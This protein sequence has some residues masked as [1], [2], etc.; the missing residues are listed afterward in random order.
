MLDYTCAPWATACAHDSRFASHTAGVSNCVRISAVEMTASREGDSRQIDLVIVTSSEHI[1]EEEQY[2]SVQEDRGTSRRGEDHLKNSSNNTIKQ[3]SEEQCS[4]QRLAACG[5]AGVIRIDYLKL[6]VDLCG[7]RATHAMGSGATQLRR[8]SVCGVIAA[9]RVEESMSQTVRVGHGFDSGDEYPH[10]GRWGEAGRSLS[11]KSAGHAARLGYR[12]EVVSLAAHSRLPFVVCSL[13]SGE[14]LVWMGPDMLCGAA[15]MRCTGFAWGQYGQVAWGG[16]SEGGRMVWESSLLWALGQDGKSLAAFPIWKSESTAPSQMSPCYSLQVGDDMNNDLQVDVG[17]KRLF[18][19]MDQWSS[20]DAA[21]PHIVVVLACGLLHALRVS[22]VADGL[23]H[24]FVT[25]HVLVGRVPL[26]GMPV[27]CVSAADFLESDWRAKSSSGTAPTGEEALLQGS[28]SSGSESAGDERAGGWPTLLGVDRNAVIRYEVQRDLITVSREAILPCDLAEKIRLDRCLKTVSLNSMQVIAVVMDPNTVGAG[29]AVGYV[30]ECRNNGLQDVC[31]PMSR[32]TI[33][34]F[35]SND[36]LKATV[37]RSSRIWKLHSILPLPLSEFSAISSYSAGDG[38][39]LVAVMESSRIVVLTQAPF[40]RATG[41]YDHVL[42]KDQRENALEISLQDYNP[43]RWKPIRDCRIHI[44]SDQTRVSE[45]PSVRGQLCLAFCSDGSAVAASLNDG[46]FFFA[47]GIA[48]GGAQVKRGCMAY[49]ASSM[50]D[51]FWQD[52]AAQDSHSRWIKC[53]SHEGFTGTGESAGSVGRT[54][55]QWNFGMKSCST[56]HSATAWTPLWNVVDH[57]R[58][59]SNS[60]YYHPT[61][62]EHVLLLGKLSEVEE[63]LKALLKELRDDIA[64][65]G[66]L[67]PSFSAWASAASSTSQHAGPKLKDQQQGSGRRSQSPCSPRPVPVAPAHVC[68][69]MV[70]GNDEPSTE[71][72]DSRHETRTKSNQVTGGGKEAQSKFQ[73]LKGVDLL[74]LKRLAAMKLPDSSKLGPASALISRQSLLLLLLPDHG[75]HLWD[76]SQAKLTSAPD[77]SVLLQAIQAVESDLDSTESEAQLPAHDAGARLEGV[78]MDNGDSAVSEVKEA[79]EGTRKHNDQSLE[80]GSDALFGPGS[81]KASPRTSVNSLPASPGYEAAGETAGQGAAGI[82]DEM[83]QV[84]SCLLDLL[85]GMDAG[86]AR[87]AASAFGRMNHVADTS[88]AQSTAPNRSAD[89]SESGLKSSFDSV[90]DGGLW[91][92]GSDAASGDCCGRVLAGVGRFEVMRIVAMADAVREAQK[93]LVMGGMDEAGIVFWLVCRLW[94]HLAKLMRR[95]DSLAVPPAL[96]GHAICYG[97]HT[98]VQDLLADGLPD[99][100]EALEC[101]WVPL[102][103]DSTPRLR[104]YTERVGRRAFVDG[105]D[106]MDAMLYYVLARKLSLLQALFKKAG[107]DKIAAFLTRDFTADEKARAAARTNAYTLIGKSRHEAAAAFFVLG[108]AVQHALDLAAINLAR[109]VLALLIARLAPAASDNEQSAE[110]TAAA[111]AALVRRTLE[112]VVMGWAVARNERGV[113][114]AVKWRLDEPWQSYGILWSASVA[115]HSD[116][117]P[118]V[119]RNLA[120]GGKTARAG[121][122]GG[123]LSR[124]L[125]GE[126]EDGVST[127]RAVCGGRDHEVDNATHACTLS[128]LRLVSQRPR[129]RL[130]LRMTAP[131]A[132]PTIWV[133]LHSAAELVACGC[134]CLVIGMELLCSCAEAVSAGVDMAWYTWLATR[135]CLGWLADRIR[136]L[137]AEASRQSL[138]DICPQHQLSKLQAEM[139][140]LVRRYGVRESVLVAMLSRFCDVRGLRRMHHALVTGHYGQAGRDASLAAVAVHPLTL[141]IMEGIAHLPRTLHT[142]RHNQAVLARMERTGKLLQLVLRSLTVDKTGDTGTLAALAASVMAVHFMLVLGKSDGPSLRR[143][144]L[145]NEG[146]EDHDS[147]M[148]LAWLMEACD[149][150]HFP[151]GGP[152]CARSVAGEAATQSDVMEPQ[153]GTRSAQWLVERVVAQ[154]RVKCLMWLLASRFHSRL[155]MALSGPPVEARS[156]DESEIGST[157]AAGGKQGQSGN[158]T[159]AETK[160]E[161][162]RRVLSP[163]IADRGTPSQQRQHSSAPYLAGIQLPAPPELGMQLPAA[164]ANEIQSHASHEA[165]DRQTSVFADSIQSD[166][167]EAGVAS[168]SPARRLFS[169]VKSWARKRSSSLDQI[170]DHL[171]TAARKASA[172]INASPLHVSTSTPG[173]PFAVSASAT[174]DRGRLATASLGASQ[175]CIREYDA[176]EPSGTLRS[177]RS[178][179]SWHEEGPARAEGRRRT[180]SGLQILSE[181][182]GSTE[183]GRVCKSESLVGS[184]T[185]WPGGLLPRQKSGCAYPG[186]ISVASPQ[187]SMSRAFFVGRE[188]VLS[189]DSDAAARWQREAPERLGNELLR[190]I[191]EWSRRLRK[192]TEVAVAVAVIETGR[193]VGSFREG[194]GPGVGDDGKMGEGSDREGGDEVVDVT[195]CG[196]DDGL[197]WAGLWEHYRGLEH[198]HRLISQTLMCDDAG[199]HGPQLAVR[200]AGLHGTEQAALLDAWGECQGRNRVLGGLDYPGKYSTRLQITVVRADLIRPPPSSLLML[201]HAVKTASILSL[202]PMAAWGGGIGPGAAA[203]RPV[204]LDHMALQAGPWAGDFR[205]TTQVWVTFQSLV[206]PGGPEAEWLSVRVKSP[207]VRRTASPYYGFCETVMVPQHPCTRHVIR[208]ELVE[209][210]NFGEDVVAAGWCD[211][212]GLAASARPET[213]TV[214]MMR[215]DGAAATSLGFESEVGQGNASE[216]VCKLELEV[217]WWIQLESE[218]DA[219]GFSTGSAPG[220]VAWY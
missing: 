15:E 110:E 63:R 192:E 70:L 103:L 145:R 109:P 44:G 71:A 175:A 38:S 152:A 138:G 76:A 91:T 148:A 182:A 33:A 193:T 30:L 132:V 180:A 156:M 42:K 79:D 1:P 89:E 157:A 6:V 8:C 207:W 113:M 185:C 184:E 164:D 200:A 92:L 203:A 149:P 50:S 9:G 3:S 130:A 29:S 83:K 208:L 168:S 93:D 96:N 53:Q 169:Q 163:V 216:E 116:K 72:G 106:P 122:L 35:V 60:V 204:S 194:A 136:S 23:G 120:S 37:H 210:H 84:S 141:W 191:G 95:F 101:L 196:D 178:A 115:A 176:D 34:G 88:N 107:Q 86:C 105:Q 170:Q 205:P 65:P 39:T 162:A 201:G 147:A 24:P 61:I 219:W 20:E 97:L 21:T 77:W 90:Q 119:A 102:W 155:A 32:F 173:L 100:R 66:Y 51:S 114:H 25:N 171:K 123:L 127:E 199:L 153:S 36:E 94:C 125:D 47:A 174:A 131:P 22:V 165:A 40:S 111:E 18:C 159:K 81:G 67:S 99:D 197:G 161:S 85:V 69:P 41:I 28:G 62:L 112:Q 135:A 12:G 128:L 108:G 78:G 121:R 179:L 160:A 68:S 137:S 74:P 218:D 4:S 48:D 16:W 45:Q 133:A 142:Q 26:N 195:A 118:S 139:G 206:D 215:G 150:A 31:H 5:G 80:S 19:L 143:L 52:L 220:A 55:P 166:A 134:G 104:S 7:T 17:E 214:A 2:N 177:F 140:R 129:M 13:V 181:R 217:R 172:C 58:C 187:N 54:C 167:A 124:D 56:G 57:L 75:L 209:K 126:D 202:Q 59:G 190:A 73:A 11:L 46:M 188:G 117:S 27:V 158:D 151:V 146:A 10:R 43:C 49:R 14:V 189:E 198:L 154:V 87:H 82:S 144:L 212:S 64:S 186:H 211:V 98:D 213:V 183:G